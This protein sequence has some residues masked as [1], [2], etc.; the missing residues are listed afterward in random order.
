MAEG[1]AIVVISVFTYIALLLFQKRRSGVAWKRVLRKRDPWL[2]LNL[3]I[4]LV[5]GLAFAPIVL[6][7][8]S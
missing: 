6:R 8:F 4:A 7:W 1:V 3:T 5:C 2:L